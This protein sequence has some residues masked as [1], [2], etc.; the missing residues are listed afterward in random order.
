MGAEPAER[1]DEADPCLRAFPGLGPGEW[2]R[3]ARDWRGDSL[4]VDQWMVNGAET[5]TSCGVVLFLFNW[6]T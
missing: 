3:R 4:A 5:A 6:T 2:N 1:V